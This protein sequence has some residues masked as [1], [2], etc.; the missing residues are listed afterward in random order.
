[1]SGRKLT[2]VSY[3]ILGFITR[4]PRSG[5]D[6]KQLT[7][8]STSFFFAASYGQIYPELK[9]LE[10]AG[11]A[12]SKSTPQ[13]KRERTEYLATPAGIEALQ[14]WIRQN[15]TSWDLKDEGLLRLFFADDADRSDQRSLIQAM[16]DEHRLTL[17]TLEGLNESIGEELLPT[18]K[19]VLDWGI[20]FGT[21][22]CEWCERQLELLESQPKE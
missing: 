21:F 19:M 12:T 14:A 13:G 3:A 10:E 16:L 7:D 9:K 22:Y 6:I 4:M 17:R 15:V 5:Y 8:I 20:G 11:L 1:M 2:P 18:S